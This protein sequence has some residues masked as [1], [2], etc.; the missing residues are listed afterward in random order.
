MA[1]F[2]Y[3][4]RKIIICI[5]VMLF[6]LAFTINLQAATSAIGLAGFS[7]TETVVDFNSIA[8]EELITT[9]FV[10]SGVTFSGA[11]YGMTHAGDIA[12]FPNPGGVI[13]SNWL[14]SQGAN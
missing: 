4:L 8:D 7:G 3:S 6:A 10:G 5:S 9:Q 1:G 14:Y 13:A 12:L 2:R 11:I